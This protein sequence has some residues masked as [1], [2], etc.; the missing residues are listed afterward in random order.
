M[1]IAVLGATGMAGTEITREAATRGH[2]VVAIS[3][4]PDRTPHPAGVEHRR[5]DL[6]D[7]LNA[8]GAA[9]VDI[10]LTDSDWAV[11]CVRF[12]PGQEHRI[13]EVTEMVLSR[14]AD[15]GARVLIIGGSS[16]LRAPGES[17]RLVMDSPWVPAAYRDVA[18]ASL[19]QFRVCSGHANRDW[20]YVSPPAVLDTGQRT[21]RYQRGTDTLL[22]DGDGASRISA[23]DLA[24]AILDEIEHPS[25]ARHLTFAADTTDTLA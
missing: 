6:L 10:G 21:G 1:K 9:S 3:R 25:G 5:I 4:Q 8:R 17:S 14:A 18:Q 24:L 2:D 11:L 23:A 15:V 13:C 16:C 20:V 19:D 7:A 12:P 22:V